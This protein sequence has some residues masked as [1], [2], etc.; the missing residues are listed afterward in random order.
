MAVL[1]YLNFYPMEDV[2]WFL[3]LLEKS[4]YFSSATFKKW[5]IQKLMIL[6]KKHNKEQINLQ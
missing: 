6:A 4:L 5:E 2:E 1:A 3:L